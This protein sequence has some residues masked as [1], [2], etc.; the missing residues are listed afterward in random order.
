MPPGKDLSCWLAPWGCGFGV[1]FAELV[2]I[3]SPLAQTGK[4]PPAMAETWVRYLGWED[5]WRREQQPTAVF[6]PGD[7]HGQRSFATV[8]GVIKSQTRLSNFHFI[9]ANV[10]EAVNCLVIE[11]K[12]TTV[13]LNSRPEF[14]QWE[15]SQKNWNFIKP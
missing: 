4:N 10:K 9:F 14:C 11:E 7:F 6:R 12:E 8:H 2:F 15:Y 13:L 3:S 5:P 1:G